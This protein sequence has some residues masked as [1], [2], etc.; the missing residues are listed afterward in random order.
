MR[1]PVT[2]VDAMVTYVLVPGAGGDSRYWH[3]VT[4]LL[5]E[6]G[7][8]VVP[9]D[10]PAADDTA[11]FPEYADAIVAAVGNRTHIV[12]VAQSLGGFSAPL[13]CDRLPVGLLVLLNAM[14][15]APHENA[16]DWWQNTGY[17]RDGDFDM[18][19]DF[20]HDVPPDVTAEIMAAGER[21]Q[22]DHPFAQPWPLEMWPP[23]PT[24]FLQARDDRFFPL[25]F[26]R[27]VVAE[28]LGI[29]I[30]EMPG[31]HL[32]ALSRPEELVER[33]ETYRAS[34]FSDV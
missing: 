34:I 12:L 2:T 10:L 24:R 20:F 14:V 13:V 5:W 16:E 23:V 27:R 31:G 26:Q 11:G 28:R 18:M 4:P 6:R 15:P 32:V 17:S 7:H 3:R 25:E 8:D 33:L 1:R 22:S 21:P 29:D 19:A 30:D 9:V